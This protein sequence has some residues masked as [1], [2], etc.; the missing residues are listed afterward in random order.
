MIKAKKNTPRG[1]LARLRRQIDALDSEL[2]ELLSRRAAVV[3]EV[4]REKRRAKLEIHDKSREDTILERLSRLNEERGGPLSGETIRKIW[5]SLMEQYRVFEREELL[6]EKGRETEQRKTVAIIGLGLMG[7]SVALALR[8]YAPRYR[9]IGFDPAGLPAPLARK[10]VHRVA[11]SPEEALRADVVI[12]AMPVGAIRDFLRRYRGSFLPGSLVMDLG[13]T[14]RAICAEA[15]RLPRSVRFVGG[16]P[17]AG[18]AV[19]GAANADAGLFRDRPFVLVG[20]KA[21]GVAALTEASELVALLGAVPIPLSAERHDQVLAVTSHLPQLA[22]VALALVGRN[23]ARTGPLVFG[24]AFVELTRLALSDYEM[25]RDIARSNADD[26]I[27]ALKEYQRVLNVLRG[28]IRR[29]AF[30]RQF[31]EAKE[32]REKLVL[33]SGR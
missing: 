14:K 3:A 33:P 8:E 7:G 27:E 31:R 11:A 32:F 17:L 1:K 28:T 9:R 30:R 22:S 2:L 18:K 23:R 29:G 24:P 19:S 6:R 10:L 13:S 26:I 16:H 20:R 15:E 25:W 5:A 12:L 21:S 4:G